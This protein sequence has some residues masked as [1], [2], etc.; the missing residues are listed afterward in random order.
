M[1]STCSRSSPSARCIVVSQSS[2]DTVL[3]FSLG[4][5]QIQPAEFAKFTVLLALCAYLSEERSNE[6]SYA[7]FLGGLLIVGVPAV[8]LI[9]QPD[10]G[11]ASV[12]IAMAM[13]VLLVAGAKARYI[14]TISVLSLVTVGAAFVGNLVNK[15]QLERVRVFFDEDNP[16]LSSEVYQVDAT[17]SG[18]S[19]PAACSARAGCRAR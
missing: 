11:S 7:R 15:Y 14:V 6:V 17:P 19:A 8:M 9:V 3:A 18:R 13:G 4:P 12:L 5:I 2:G 10:L 1:G 16:A